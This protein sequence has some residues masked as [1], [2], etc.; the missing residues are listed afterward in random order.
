MINKLREGELLMR[1]TIALV[2]L[3]ALVVPAASLT[4]DKGEVI[5]A[6]ELQAQL[7]QLAPQAKDTGSSGATLMHY[8]NLT[9]KLSVR[10][11]SGGAEIHAHYDDLMIVEQGTATLITGGT[12]IDAKTGNDGETDGTGIQNGKA[13]TIAAGDVVIVP[14]GVPHQLLIPPHTIY[15]AMVAKVKE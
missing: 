4:G 13:Q 5:A 14:A 12:V 15:G 6:N 8:G 3:I 11:S 7:K 1:L 2:S 9:L 10:S